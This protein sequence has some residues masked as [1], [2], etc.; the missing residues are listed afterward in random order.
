MSTERVAAAQ[1]RQLVESGTARPLLSGFEIGPTWYAGAWWHVPADGSDGPN[2][3]RAGPEL[4]ADLDRL[5]ERSD[6][7]DAVLAEAEARAGA[8]GIL[9]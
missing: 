6:R 4:S 3:H 2:Y 7:I 1:M 9:R 8:P 5:K